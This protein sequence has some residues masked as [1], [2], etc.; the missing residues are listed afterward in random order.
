M[1]TDIIQVNYEAIHDITKR[2]LH[3]QE[4]Q[5]SMTHELNHLLDS[6]QHTG[7]S[8]KAADKMIAE[9]NDIVFPSL[10]RL[11][12]VLE[13]TSDSLKQV[14]SVMRIG[15]EEAGKLFRAQGSNGGGND[16][17]SKGLE[18]GK[19][20][21]EALKG[22][23]KP[24]FLSDHVIGEG[25]T[26]TSHPGF[27]KDEFLVQQSGACMLYG[28]MNLLVQHGIDISQAEAD[29]IYTDL[30]A[31]YG[32]TENFPLEAVYD[33]FDQ[34]GVDYEYGNFKE[35]I[36]GADFSPLLGTN[37]AAAEAF[38]V[39]QIS[40]GKS[41]FVTSETDDIFGATLNGS[42]NAG[43]A[44]TI[45]GVQQDDTGK[46][47]NVLAVTNWANEPYRQIPMEHFMKD[48]MELLQGEYFIVK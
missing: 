23:L 14:V 24:N 10:K 6:L 38:L 37:E 33:I 7:W 3:L 21:G 43:H 34:Y 30:S 19:L 32:I 31:K 47:T 11:E 22:N 46:V 1:A 15:E 29:Q 27:M 48:W 40:Q 4:R 16:V 44:Y 18:M 2:L 39:E 28:P 5:H 9:M 26:F 35:R 42:A 17:V 41:V 45:V 8:G 36:L 25:W 20:I 12:N 13:K